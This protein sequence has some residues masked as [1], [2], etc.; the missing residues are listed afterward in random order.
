[1][2]GYDE[3][4]TEAPAYRKREEA[5]KGAR[6]A[7]AV[8]RA[9]REYLEDEIRNAQAQID[10]IR[11]RADERIEPYHRSILHMQDQLVRLTPQV[12]GP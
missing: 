2:T 4:D 7:D 5:L 6:D 3:L 1:M 8:V 9:Q 11:R 10:E 12:D